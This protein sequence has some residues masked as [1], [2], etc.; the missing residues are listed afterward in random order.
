[1][2]SWVNKKTSTINY[3]SIEQNMKVDLQ[4]K[5]GASL[6]AVLLKME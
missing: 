6:T 2:T 5:R 4:A 3:H 1:M